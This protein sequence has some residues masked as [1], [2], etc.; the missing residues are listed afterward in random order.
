MISEK[1]LQLLAKQMG[2]S[3]SDKEIAELEE[4]LS[5]HPEYHYFIEILQSIEGKKSHEEPIMKESDLVQ[6][7]WALLKN[8]L[9]RKLPEDTLKQ[10]VKSKKGLLKKWMGQA[11]IWVAAI[12][13]FC[14][15]FFWQRE[16]TDQHTQVASAALKEVSLSYGVPEK[17]I[18]PD[19]S[20]VWLNAGSNIRYAENFLQNKR[21]VYL[22]GEAYF[23]IKQDAAHPFVV[24]AGNIVIRVL[25]TEFNVQA[26]VE[27]NQIET[28]LVNGKIQ[29]Q[30]DGRPDKKI[31]LMPNEK[32][33]VHNEVFHLS[34]G[35][36]KGR[37]E[38][39]FKVQ[40]VTP[41]EKIDQLPEVA[42]MQDKLVFQN[43]S[44]EDVAKSLERRY[45]VH[46]IFRN[47]QLSN[48]KLTGVFENET[49]GKALKILQMTT[50]FDYQI[51]NDTVYI[52]KN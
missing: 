1:I 22:E 31:V 5:A 37:K 33:T 20:I 35:K 45:D 52:I 10:E 30:I 50:P 7:S 27:E 29:V 24:H 4:L 28:T 34:G 15:A 11:A 41:M 42:W 32:L 2:H 16:V 9:E 13:T 21:E 26:Y 6:E 48:E 14:G 43:E 49:I 44:F 19:S 8:E 25:G 38:L 51:K 12:V 3:A 18:L 40:E 23:K 47:K 36:I 39:S 17:R 46:I